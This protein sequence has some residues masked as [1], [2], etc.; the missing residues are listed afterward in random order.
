[1]NMQVRYL[2]LCSLILVVAATPLALADPIVYLAERTSDDPA[3][4]T[5]TTT[6]TTITTTTTTLPAV[7]GLR[8]RRLS[9]LGVF[10]VSTPAPA[11]S[12]APEIPRPAPRWTR[13]TR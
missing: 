8:S 6:T 1:M 10:N 9:R 5:A 7:R 12:V 11:I 13:L 2:T 4:P 3:D